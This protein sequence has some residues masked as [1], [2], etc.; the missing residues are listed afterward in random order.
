MSTPRGDVPSIRDSL[1]TVPSEPSRSP[2]HILTHDVNVLLRHLHELEET[3]G[4][5]IQEILE[6]VRT[7]RDNVVELMEDRQ[8]REVVVEHVREVEKELPPPVPMKDSAVGGSSEVSS[9]RSAVPR[10]IAPGPLPTYT[11]RPSTTPRL[12]PIPVTPPPMRKRLASP[13]TLTETMSFL[14]SHHSDDFSLMESET[15]PDRAPSPSWSSPSSSPASS[16]VSSV[17]V[18]LPQESTS[19]SSVS[20]ESSVSYEDTRY[21]RPPASPT[22]SST[23]SATARP[24][25]PPDVLRLREL[26]QDVQH[27]VSAL[28]AEQNSTNHMLDDLIHRPTGTDMDTQNRLYRIEEIVQRIL[29][30]LAQPAPAPAPIPTPGPAPSI[31]RDDMS[32]SYTSSSH[33]SSAIARLQEAFRTGF[34]DEPP[35]LHMPRPM[36]AGPTFSELLAQTLATEALPPRSPIQPPPALVTLQFRPGARAARPRS[37]SPTFETTLPDRAQTVPITRP[38]VFSES[39]SRPQRVPHRRRQAAA[40]SSIAESTPYIPPVVPIP[41]PG[42]RVRTPGPGTAPPPPDNGD[43]IDMEREVRNLRSQ[44]RPDQS[45]GVY[46]PGGPTPPPRVRKPVCL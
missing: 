6:N 27:Q 18:P 11:Q 39:R 3:R 20:P 30:Q 44:R 1:L 8:S 43:D 40:P 25:P 26:L 9:A 7:I 45:D 23:S 16:P 31:Q 32:E 21:L 35:P 34:G 10:R 28:G 36:P 38:V 17:S 46:R 19:V 22:P 4:P 2:S 33:V 37:A 29:D 5:Q 12:I 14:S 13:D 15:Y 41:A 24:I 42:T